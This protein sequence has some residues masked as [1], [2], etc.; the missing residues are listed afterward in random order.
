MAAEGRRVKFS[1]GMLPR[2]ATHVPVN[3]PTLMHFQ[4][5]LNGTQGIVLKREREHMKLRKKQEG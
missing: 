1:L 2:K 3:D 4:T 5:V